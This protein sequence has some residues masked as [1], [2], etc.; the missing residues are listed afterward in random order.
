MG[1]HRE[2]GGRVSTSARLGEGALEGRT[3]NDGR[4]GRRWSELVLLE[5]LLCYRLPT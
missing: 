5:V 3:M 4:V 1:S 2:G